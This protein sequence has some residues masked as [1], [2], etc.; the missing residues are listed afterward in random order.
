L[1]LLFSL[2]LIVGYAVF[3]YGG[4]TA[5]D[6]SFCLAALC[7][8]AAVVWLGGPGARLAPALDRKLSL[9]LAVFAAYAALQ[10]VPLPMAWL[11][12]LSP[13]RA[14]LLRAVM[15]IDA[16][17]TGAPISVAP[18]VTFAHLMRLLAYILVFFLVREAAW[19]AREK[20]WQLAV[21]VIGIAAFEAGL[22][23]TQ[24]FGGASSATGTYVNHNHYAGLL[25]MAFPLAVALAAVVVRRL[26]RDRSGSIPWALLACLPIACSAL[27]FVGVIYSFSRMGLVVAIA[28]TAILAVLGF[29]GRSAG[30]RR[31]A[32]ALALLAISLILIF[33]AIPN[34]LLDRFADTPGGDELTADAR[35]QIWKETLHLIDAYPI[36]GTGLGTYASAFQKYRASS[37]LSL[38]DFAHNDYLQ[39]LAELGFA[40]FIPFAICG[41]LVFIR[42]LR[43]AVTEARTRRRLLAA[44]CAASLCAIAMHSVVDFNLYIPANAMVVAWVAGIGSALEFPSHEKSRF[45]RL[46]VFRQREVR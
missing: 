6:W 33:L 41:I 16:G 32:G 12:V 15:G 28:S 31:A 35:L 7:I 21:P 38:V 22:G 27:I 3:Q 8:V 45:R 40:G 18:S 36:F 9:L 14:E 25:E 24:Y 43:S 29:S 19:R 11:R 42:L 5:P 2:T 30:K 20:T 1:V 26:Y 39:L 34:G 13:A 44:G 23:L 46:S 10:L 4:V 17:R 37:L